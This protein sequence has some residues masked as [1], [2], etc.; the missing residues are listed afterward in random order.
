MTSSS[1][2]QIFKGIYFYNIGDHGGILVAVQYFKTHGE[3][4]EILYSTDEGEHWQRHEF[5]NEDLKLYGLMTEPGGNTT[6]FTMFGSVLNKHKWLI[7][8]VNL[9][10]AFSK[11]S[12]L[13]LK[14]LSK[15]TQLNE[16]L[17]CR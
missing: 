8:K 17:K 4:R 14:V 2:S 10:N 5:S 16:R 7:V 6:V 12:L 9:R 13:V 15:E 1:F 3:T 11:C